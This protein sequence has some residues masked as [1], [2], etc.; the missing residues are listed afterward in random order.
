MALPDWWLDYL[1]DVDHGWV[2]GLG[3]AEASDWSLRACVNIS[4]LQKIKK[5]RRK[6]TQGHTTRRYQY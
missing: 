4:H 5:N 2:R 3:P 1:C 6:N